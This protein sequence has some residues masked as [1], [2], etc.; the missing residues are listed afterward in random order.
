L[1]VISNKEV[2]SR[3]V[4][5]PVTEEGHGDSEETKDG[6]T[7]IVFLIVVA[8]DKRRSLE[9]SVN[10]IRVYQTKVAKKNF[11]SKVENRRRVGRP[12]FR[13]L[14]DLENSLREPKNEEM[15]TEGN[16]KKSSVLWDIT[17]CSPLK[18]NRLFGG[19]CRLN[20]QGRRISQARKQQAASELGLA[21]S[22]ILKLETACYSETSANFNGLH[23]VISQSIELFKTNSRII[24]NKNWH[25]SY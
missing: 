4:C 11:E 12:S 2:I 5:G 13:S 19:T 6:Q 22:S 18:V 21:Y 15:H 10:V 3:K 14:E 23:G 7:C 8:D 20:L 9:W 25:L 16:N 1:A 17:Q 24:N